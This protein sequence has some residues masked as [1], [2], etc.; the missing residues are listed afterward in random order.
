QFLDGTPL[1]FVPEGLNEGFTF[2]NP[3]VT[4]ECGCGESFHV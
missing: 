3:N 1:D 4:A 2:T